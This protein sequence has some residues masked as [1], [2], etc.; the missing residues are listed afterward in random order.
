MAYSFV[1]LRQQLNYVSILADLAPAAIWDSRSHSSA[2]YIAICL[3][4]TDLQILNTFIH[5]I[6]VARCWF[7][8]PLRN[9]TPKTRQ[10][11][12]AAEG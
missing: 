2:L 9:L 3:P 8:A 6:M 11:P 5:A 10:S 4:I 7:C 1:G 12:V